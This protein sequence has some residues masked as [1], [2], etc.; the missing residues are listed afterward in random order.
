MQGFQEGH[1]GRS[2]G[3]G[4]EESYTKRSM[5]RRL[6]DVAGQM[7]SGDDLDGWMAR[8]PGRR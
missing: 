4:K 8:R 3:Q 2:A 7:T 1:T 6:E 5:G